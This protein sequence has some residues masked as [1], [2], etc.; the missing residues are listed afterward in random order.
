MKFP[1]FLVMVNSMSRFPV[2]FAL[3]SVAAH[4]I[5]DC[6]LYV[7]SWFGIRLPIVVIMLLCFNSG[8]HERF[9]CT[10][11]FITVR[12]SEANG[13]AERFVG[14]VKNINGQGFCSLPKKVFGISNVFTA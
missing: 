5:G 11:W 1:Y 12:H 4:S 7:S 9:G 14:T 8:G 10:P 13:L 2:A 3:K 6:L